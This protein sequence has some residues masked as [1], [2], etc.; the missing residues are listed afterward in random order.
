MTDTLDEVMKTSGQLV[1]EIL[2]DEWVATQIGVGM[3]SPIVMPVNSTDEGYN[4][5]TQ[6]VT[7]YGVIARKPEHQHIK[8]PDCHPGL[9]LP[10]GWEPIPLRSC[11][12][13]W[14]RG[15]SVILDSV[16]IFLLS[17]NGP[18]IPEI[19]SRL[20]QQKGQKGGQ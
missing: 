19:L 3:P 5:W 1:Q 20:K 11:S 12:V 7:C 6:E 16:E 15:V 13:F 4:E 14:Y 17:Q 8:F 2:G 10:E 9:P 18:A